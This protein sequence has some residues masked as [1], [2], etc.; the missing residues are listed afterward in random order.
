MAAYGPGVRDYAISA[1]ASP[2]REDAPRCATLFLEA[3]EE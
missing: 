2:C 1:T 3:A